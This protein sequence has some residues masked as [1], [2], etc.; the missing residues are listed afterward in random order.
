MSEME[1]TLQAV[2]RAIE[3]LEAA[4]IHLSDDKMRRLYAQRDELRALIA[5]TADETMDETMGATMGAGRA[6]Q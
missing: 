4:G 1:R 3:L 5:N 2:T 6:E